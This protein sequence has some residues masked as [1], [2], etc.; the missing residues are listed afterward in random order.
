MTLD[1]EVVFLEIRLGEASSRSVVS[2]LCFR[3][4]AEDALAPFCASFLAAF[5]SS[6]APLVLMNLAPI[7]I[8]VPRAARP[9][10]LVGLSAFSVAA[11]SKSIAVQYSDIASPVEGEIRWRW[12]W[13]TS[14]V[15]SPICCGL[16]SSSVV[17]D[18]PS[19]E[20]GERSVNYFVVIAR[21]CLFH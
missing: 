8:D 18:V 11:R 13:C 6:V 15:V 2:P 4:L 1:L 3:F 14:A 16:W 10:L 9:L 7:E 5:E 12:I 19:E 17:R 20:G 21:N